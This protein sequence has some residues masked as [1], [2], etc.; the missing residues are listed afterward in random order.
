MS[1]IALLV[2]FQMVVIYILKD[3]KKT[4]GQ[5]VLL[6]SLEA[7]SFELCDKTLHSRTTPRED[8]YENK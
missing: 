6:G 2:N 1:V 4:C 8:A 7:L 5:T 3:W